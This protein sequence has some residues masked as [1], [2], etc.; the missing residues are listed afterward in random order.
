VLAPARIDRVWRDDGDQEV[1]VDD[2]LRDL[3]DERVADMQD[4]LVVTDVQALRLQVG[5][6]LDDQLLVFVRVA[7][8]RRCHGESLRA[9]AGTTKRSR[10]HP[11]PLSTRSS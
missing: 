11:V 5:R 10:D 8:E 2:L 6:Q 3:L 4:D 9:A 1:P 7:D